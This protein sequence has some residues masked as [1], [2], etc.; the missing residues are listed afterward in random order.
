MTIDNAY[1]KATTIKK[2]DKDFPE[3]LDF[4]ALRNEGLR[5]IGALSGKLW[6]DHNI[7]DPGITTL[8]VL[9][10]AILDLG[11]RTSR[12]IENLLA[13]DAKG[14]DDN[15]FS[16][17]QILTNNPL[18][19]TDYR[20]LLIA[21]PEVRNAWV[22]V[23]DAS[24]VQVQIG[25]DKDNT[26]VEALTINGLYKILI[27]PN[28]DYV[29]SEPT[30]KPSEGF[31]TL[32]TVIPKISQIDLIKKINKLLN[33]H[34]NLCE[35]F[36]PFYEKNN[37]NNENPSAKSTILQA[38][39]LVVKG[40]VLLQTQADA[41]RVY[42][43]I[44]RVIAEF[45]APSPRFYTLQELLDKGKTIEEI[46]E[47]RPSM[48]LHF[49]TLQ[50][51]LEENRTANAE[52]ADISTLLL[53]K[54]SFSD[55]NVG[56][57]D[58]D[59]LEKIEPRKEIHIS[60]LY[61]LVSQIEGV[62]SVQILQLEKVFST[63]NQS[64][65]ATKNWCYDIPEGSVPVL[66]DL[67][68]T[69]KQGVTSAV[70]TTNDLSNFEKKGGN[71][72]KGVF[73]AE[74]V[75]YA[76]P[77]ED[78]G[79]YYSI[80][81]DFPRVYRIGE[82]GLSAQA[83]DKEVAQTRQFKGYLLFFERILT[84][85]LA[86]LTHIRDI[87]SIL[88]DSQKSE[89][90]RHTYFSG[91]L[92]NVPDGDVLLRFA[93]SDA[94]N[95]A[96]TTSLAVPT[97]GSALTHFFDELL[98]F[99]RQ[100][101]I[102]ERINDLEVILLEID[103]LQVFADYLLKKPLNSTFKTAKSVQPQPY[104]SVFQRDAVAHLLRQNLENDAFDIKIYED[105]SGFVFTV[106]PSVGSTILLSRVHYPTA[107]KARE[108]AALT[109]LVGSFNAGF[110]LVTTPKT[111][112]H[113]DIYTFDIVSSPAETL[114]LLNQSLENPT[115]YAQRRN[116]LLDHLLARFAEQFTDY[117]TLLYGIFNDKTEDKARTAHD[118]A[119]FLANYDQI[120]QN[121]ARAFD[122]TEGSWLTENVSG[123]EQRTKAFAAI[124]DKRRRTLCPFVIDKCED[125][126]QVKITDATGNPLFETADAY[127]R[128]VA[129]AV[130]QSFT[131]G[132]Q[133]VGNFK[134]FE[135]ASKEFGFT[136]QTP[137]ATLAHPILYTLESER[138]EKI[139]QIHAVFRQNIAE[140]EIFIF[141]TLWK[142]GLYEAKNEADL[143]FN[144]AIHFSPIANETPHEQGKQNE[145]ESTNELGNKVENQSEN[146]G[147]NGEK[148]PVQVGKS[149]FK[150]SADALENTDFFTKNL[151]NEGLTLL[152]DPQQAGVYVNV[153]AF[154]PIVSTLPPVYRWHILNNN[155]LK[156][157]GVKEMPSEATALSDFI[158][159]KTVKEETICE[160]I[161]IF[162]TETGFKWSIV[163]NDVVLLNSLAAFADRETA[164]LEAFASLDLVRDVKRYF[165]SGDE[166]NANFTFLLRDASNRFV[167]QHPNVFSKEKE[168]AKSLKNVQNL[169][170]NAEKPLKIQ[171]EPPRYIW[172]LTNINEPQQAETLKSFSYFD[173]EANALTNFNLM[174]HLAAKKAAY[175]II[176]NSESTIYNFSI[177]NKEVPCAVSTSNFDTL[178][179]CEKA[180]NDW[181]QHI[182]NHRYTVQ[183]REYPD[184]YKFQYFAL[185]TDAAPLFISEK[186]FGSAAEATEGFN[187]FIK[188]LHT[189]SLIDNGL[190]TRDG[191]RAAQM[192]ETSE[193]TLAFVEDLKKLRNTEGSLDSAVQKS[194]RS[195][196]GQYVYRM[197]DKD[198]P[199]AFAMQKKS[200]KTDSIN[201]FEAP[202]YTVFEANTEGLALD[203][204]NEFVKKN[205]ATCPVL[206][207]CLDGDNVVYIGNQWFYTLKTNH[208]P[209][210]DATAQPQSDEILFVSW[211]GY[212]TE[213]EAHAA[214]AQNYVGDIT[215]ATNAANY[216][217]P[218]GI[219]Y[220]QNAPISANEIAKNT[221]IEEENEASQT[222]NSNT[223]LK[224]Q[225]TEGAIAFPKPTNPRIKYRVFVPKETA[226]RYSKTQLATFAQSYPLR[227][228]LENGKKQYIFVQNDCNTSDLM[229][230]S[231]E[232]FATTDSALAT[233]Q[234]FHAMLNVGG[235]VRLSQVNNCAYNVGLFEILLESKDRFDVENAWENVAKLTDSASKNDAL[236]VYQAK[237][238]GDKWSF[239]GISNCFRLATSPL[240]FSS[241]QECTQFLTVLTAAD[242]KISISNDS[243]TVIFTRK[244]SEKA[245]VPCGCPEKSPIES[246]Q[247]LAVLN[248]LNTGGDCRQIA[249]DF[250]KKIEN[251]RIISTS[252]QSAY[253]FELIDND[254][255][256]AKHPLSY[257]TRLQTETTLK[258]ADKCL[259]TEGIHIVEKILLRPRTSL[260]R[261]RCIAFADDV[262]KLPYQSTENNTTVTH[263]ESN[264]C[265]E[266]LTT[267]DTPT[268]VND[269]DNTA[270]YLPDADPY[271]F[272]LKIIMPS[273][274]RRFGNLQFRRELERLF[275]HE[276]PAYIWLDI[277]YKNA[278]DLCDFETKYR[279]WLCDFKQHQTA[280]NLLGDCT[281][282]VNDLNDVNDVRG[283]SAA[284][285]A[286]HTPSVSTILEDIKSVEKD[287][288]EAKSLEK[289]DKANKKTENDRFIR[290]R[291]MRY[292]D[293]IKAIAD[294]KLLKTES[295]KQTAFFLQNDGNVKALE[296]LMDLITKKSL[297]KKGGATDEQYWVL[298]ENALGY[299]LDKL[300]V[301]TP[302]TVQNED[303][304][305]GIAEKIKVQ[306]IDI[307]GLMKNWH[308]EEWV[309]TLDST[310]VENY[311][312]ILSSLRL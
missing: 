312:T 73:Q 235:A 171:A 254:Q 26:R 306:N 277:E 190:H 165:K 133:N 129:A 200:L 98:N 24:K 72:S 43:E 120:S 97:E 293:N 232:T 142:I 71:Q 183:T 210:A 59:E 125:E 240:R 104:S 220:T 7:H 274:G 18:T 160:N 25:N 294:T 252:Q 122:Y 182:A 298:L 189:K 168:R 42:A 55:L 224:T 193:R 259:H 41:A 249:I 164:L 291:L 68:L 161:R 54:T 96:L 34:R 184:R 93:K 27:E 292:F 228:T 288:N 17:H 116:V 85:Y 52:N 299:A 6:T 94:G 196:Q 283:I 61:N 176:N 16:P 163:A 127:P 282:H 275:A 267:K 128:D 172:T 45:I 84:D 81:R 181:V 213:A 124:D 5:H 201:A 107:T 130:V 118:K 22:S 289:G 243:K 207:L 255:I 51:I 209:K 247:V 221:K 162:P 103:F 47:G 179:T 131:E 50:S 143:N 38:E 263:S 32:P 266:C 197:L 302:N 39:P 234:R 37:Q 89:T 216:D 310:V 137:N 198:A 258:R 195:E 166:F 281:N 57:V 229:W 62:Q 153:A 155:V 192:W 113:D 109:A 175:Q 202:K 170:K 191:E 135:T 301:A 242:A 217:V 225:N 48:S 8:E 79:E 69:L 177:L 31:Q 233:W 278:E 237:E 1:I 145:D 208:F 194:A 214:F 70:R 20:K 156:E 123:F 108:A 169:L 264:N 121:R 272:I 56:F 147:V 308:G 276:S 236:Y 44:H 204:L 241:V 265:D 60:D 146:G 270:Y 21:L 49:P 115:L 46:Y 91:S 219:F 309:K 65:N 13:T 151:E 251:Y 250:L 101:P 226:K 174:L 245:L 238:V 269:N 58:T 222:Q 304:L 12:P 106:V 23:S 149:P 290:S 87:F 66:Q 246:E 136:F 178:E 80:Q 215:A 36:E 268:V 140:N 205:T 148:R 100:K 77:L 111:A 296:M 92:D 90:Q 63:Q 144:K 271:S 53:S 2:I 138:D 29:K 15:F 297:G 78:L 261:E 30:T 279:R 134:P 248:F 19:I 4:I 227:E 206:S 199:L 303:I 126:F 167:A 180:V 102:N 105:A 253:T 40:T 284:K 150:T 67:V 300:I 218:N 28:F 159:A 157:S 257:S 273:W 64:S 99:Y 117:T 119:Q 88:P 295:Y 14:Q 203:F 239:L 186:D 260:D 152:A 139:A 82:G 223:E 11:Y 212:D 10:Y 132:G 173:N 188:N 256:L 231:A 305:R 230:Q 262:C 110:R 33:A 187:D 185:A 311:K 114:D 86:Q 9:A 244:Y 287:D 3:W 141:S 95:A 74:P 307:E 158:T 211:Q 75:P 76:A 112:T 35:D 285:T 83:T 280:V 154:A 286:T